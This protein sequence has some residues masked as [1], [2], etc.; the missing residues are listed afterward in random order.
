MV[1]YY[2]SWWLHV[3]IFLRAFLSQCVIL[4]FGCY[5][6]VVVLFCFFL[7]RLDLF[8]ISFFLHYPHRSYCV[9]TLCGPS[10]VISDSRLE[11]MLP[12]GEAAL[13][14]YSPVHCHLLACHVLAHRQ[15]SCRQN[16]KSCP[17]TPTV[18]FFINNN[19]IPRA[20]AMCMPNWEVI[21]KCSL[22]GS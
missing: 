7:V 18:E 2:C 5:C 9:G 19:T 14:I 8:F 4:S 11:S 12:R 13:H 10:K 6:V 17:L 22:F 15:R 1:N 20:S 21:L 3:R 16:L